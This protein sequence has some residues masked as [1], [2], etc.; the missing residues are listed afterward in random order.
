MY[1]QRRR[2]LDPMVWVV[3]VISWIV[4]LVVAWYLFGRDNTPS[5]D[6]TG[7]ENSATKWYIDQEVTLQ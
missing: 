5:T 6:S 1:E 4:I 3:L 7:D 2:G